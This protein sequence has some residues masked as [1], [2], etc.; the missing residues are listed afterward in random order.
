MK[1]GVRLG[2]GGLGGRPSNAGVG[3]GRAGMHGLPKEGCGTDDGGICKHENTARAR[4]E[5][6]LATSLL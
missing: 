5:T 3:N 2:S 6:A 4:N 1:S